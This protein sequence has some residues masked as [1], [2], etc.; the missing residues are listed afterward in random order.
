[1]GNIITNLENGM[2]KMIC[3][4]SIYMGKLETIVWFGLFIQIPFCYQEELERERQLN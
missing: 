3:P 1:M 4:P 2:T